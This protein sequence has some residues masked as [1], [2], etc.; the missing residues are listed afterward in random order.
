MTNIFKNIS[1]STLVVVSVATFNV[2]ASGVFEVDNTV[3]NKLENNRGNVKH[4]HFKRLAKALSLTA[5]QKEE[6]KAIKKQSRIDSKVLKTNLEGFKD[7]MKAI[8]SESTFDEG[9]FIQLHGEY[10]QVFTQLALLKAKSKFKVMQVIDE[11]QQ[12]KAKELRKKRMSRL[13]H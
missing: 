9:K 10:Q 2:E 1:I 11:E 3:A 4:G 12:N 13:F 7:G 6:I 8:M 5:A